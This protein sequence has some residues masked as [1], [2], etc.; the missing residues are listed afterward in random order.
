MMYRSHKGFAMLYVVLVLAS[1]LVAI[2]FAS[3]LS[4]AGAGKRMRQYQQTLETRAAAYECAET[5]M[6]QFRNSPSTNTTGSFAVGDGT[7]TYAVSGSE[8]NKTITI[9]MQI[10]DTY[11]HITISTSQIYTTIESEWLEVI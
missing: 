10:D 7:C 5:V 3:A 8:P 1:I 9:D 4:G 11:K 6:M 2:S